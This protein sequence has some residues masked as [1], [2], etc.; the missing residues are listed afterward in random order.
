MKRWCWI[1]FLLI[2]IKIKRGAVIVLL[3]RL[4]YGAE[5]R[6]EARVRDW[7]SPCDDL[8]TLSSNPAVSG[9]LF[10]IR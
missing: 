4:D 3:E 9:Y 10:L 7:A 2:W 6:R 1:N 5:G 8:K